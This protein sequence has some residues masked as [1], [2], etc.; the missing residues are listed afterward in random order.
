MI[1]VCSSIFKHRFTCLLCGSGL[2]SDY[3]GG[4]YERLK[5]I[6]PVAAQRIHPNDHRKVRMLPNFPNLLCYRF[7]LCSQWYWLFCA[8]PFCMC[9]CVGKIKRYLELYATTGALPSNLFQGETAKVRNCALLG[10]FIHLAQV[11]MK[12]LPF[13]LIWTSN[14]PTSHDFFSCMRL[15]CWEFWMY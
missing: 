7:L 9:Y 10:A 1:C 2:A 4:G 15:N 3:A 11:L 8:S 13:S 5:E 12:C 6:D 14:F